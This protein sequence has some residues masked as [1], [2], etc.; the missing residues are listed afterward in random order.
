M[1]PSAAVALRVFS[2]SAIKGYQGDSGNVVLKRSRSGE[3]SGMVEARSRSVLRTDPISIS[4]K[5]SDLVVTRQTR[6]CA[7]EPPADS[8]PPV[9]SADEDSEL[10]DT[11][12]D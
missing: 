9:D 4:G 2:P 1:A 11:D 6:G 3:L 12:V 7:A 10:Y 5:F 8:A